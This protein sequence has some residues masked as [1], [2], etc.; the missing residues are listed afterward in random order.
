MRPEA[1][2]CLHG[3]SQHNPQYL[4]SLLAY[5][6]V[7]KYRLRILNRLRKGGNKQNDI[8]IIIDCRKSQQSQVITQ[9]GFPSV[10]PETRIEKEKN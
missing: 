1:L 3:I 4:V 9:Y 7:C 8:F 2:Y 5:G 6:L 10:H